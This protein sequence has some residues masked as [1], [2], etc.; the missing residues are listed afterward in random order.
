[1]ICVHIIVEAICILRVVGTGRISARGL[2]STKKWTD[3]LLV[4]SQASLV[5]NRFITPLKKK[6]SKKAM[7]TGWRTLRTSRAQF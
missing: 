4:R 5:N 3:I 2:D 7:I 6:L 1:M